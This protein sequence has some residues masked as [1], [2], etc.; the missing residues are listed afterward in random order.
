MTRSNRSAR[1]NV[2]SIWRFFWS[3]MLLALVVASS[4]LIGGFFCLRRSG[5]DSR[6]AIIAAGRRHCRT[7]RRY[8]PD[9]RGDR[10]SWPGI[11]DP[12]ADFR[13][14]PGNQHG[15]AAQGFSGARQP[16]QLLYRYRPCCPRH[17]R[18]CPGNTRL[19]PGSRLPLADCRHQ[20]LSHA[21]QP[22]GDEPRA[23][24]GRICA[25]AGPSGQP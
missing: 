16:I 5:R 1:R 2:P 3:A 12:P 17:P 8:R 4:A 15:S 22:G 20:R 6:K 23:A 18:Q 7:D 24:G 9:Q 14:R 13:R 25:G 21:A 10:P 19:G 11:G